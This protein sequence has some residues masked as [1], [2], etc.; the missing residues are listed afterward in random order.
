MKFLAQ[1]MTFALCAVAIAFSVAPSMAQTGATKKATVS[2][3]MKTGAKTHIVRHHRHHKI[4]R[5]GVKSPAQKAHV[6]K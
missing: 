2:H 5:H 4:A 1:S 3:A 6:T